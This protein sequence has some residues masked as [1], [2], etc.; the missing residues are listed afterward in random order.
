MMKFLIKDIINTKKKN[1]KKFSHILINIIITSMKVK[2]I[3]T[4]KL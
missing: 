4:L 1:K 2:Y 3:Q